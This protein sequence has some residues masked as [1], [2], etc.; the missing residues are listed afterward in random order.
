MIDTKLLPKSLTDEVKSVRIVHPW[1]HGE[2]HHPY[3]RPMLA[4][5]CTTM[6]NTHGAGS[7]RVERKE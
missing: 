6:N 1:G 5:I 2:W 3:D 7:H 4:D